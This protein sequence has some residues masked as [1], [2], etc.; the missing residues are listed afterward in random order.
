MCGWNLVPYRAPY[1]FSRQSVIAWF[2]SQTYNNLY[3]GRQDILPPNLELVLRWVV[4]YPVA[5]KA[6]GFTQLLFENEV[7]FLLWY[8]AISTWRRAVLFWR[9]HYLRLMGICWIMW[10]V[11]FTKTMKYYKWHECVNIPYFFPAIKSWECKL[12]SF[13]A[14]SDR[15]E[16][17][18]FLMCRAQNF[19]IEVFSDVISAQNW[20]LFASA[21]LKM[22]AQSW[23][24]DC[25]CKLRAC[26]GG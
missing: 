16:I 13:L 4:V 9:R 19:I 25:A 15:T 7:K 11:R 26:A 3:V 10:L 23:I 1:V 2:P 22:A 20:F 18:F 8:C 6:S 5:I 14:G 24:A 21:S 17:I 12:T